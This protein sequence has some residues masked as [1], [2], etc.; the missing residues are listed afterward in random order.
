M[1]CV[2]EG[3]NEMIT[4]T[5][6][7]AGLCLCS[8]CTCGQHK[9]PFLLKNLAAPKSIYTTI[10]KANYTRYAIRPTTTQTKPSMQRTHHKF[11]SDTT[12]KRDFVAMPLERTVSFTSPAEFKQLP[13]RVRYRSRYQDEFKRWPTHSTSISI[14]HK[15]PSQANKFLASST[16]ASN[17]DPKPIRVDKPIVPYSNG[18]PVR[19]GYYES[20]L[21]TQKAAFVGEWN[22]PQQALKKSETTVSTSSC[23]G[24]FRSSSDY[25]FGTNLSNGPLRRARKR[26]FNS[27]Y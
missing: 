18:D 6:H 10:Y 7:R 17:F 2:L 15:K 21:S 12:F 1:S 3:V 14:K 26:Y 9:C 22:K 24:Q 13:N 19:M 5:D 11:E 20:S 4:D 8:T 27:I 25:Y 23:P 16:Y